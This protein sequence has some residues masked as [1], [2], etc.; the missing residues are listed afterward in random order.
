MY[1]C[2]PIENFAT[3]SNAE[4]LARN[5]IKSVCSKKITKSQ[6]QNTYNND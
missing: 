2:R 4:G 6:W 5:L 3:V 1:A